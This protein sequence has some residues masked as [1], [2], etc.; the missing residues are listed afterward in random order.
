MLVVTVIIIVAVVVVRGVVVVGFVIDSGVIDVGV[1]SVNNPPIVSG[2]ILI[3]QRLIIEIFFSF[4]NFVFLLLF[5][6][7]D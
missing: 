1:S 4:L 3:Q 6:A 2:S 5:S 7:F